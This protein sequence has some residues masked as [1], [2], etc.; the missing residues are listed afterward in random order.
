ME[1]CKMT[2]FIFVYKKGNKIKCLEFSDGVGAIDERLRSNGWLHVATID[3][4][5]FIEH[6]QNELK[7]DIGL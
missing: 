5:I 4:C 7:I 1:G 3:P 6:L 2:Y